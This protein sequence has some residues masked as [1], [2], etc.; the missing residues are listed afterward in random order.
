LTSSITDLIH[1]IPGSLVIFERN[2]TI[3]ACNRAAE[4]LFGYT[5]GN[6]QKQNINRILPSI[7]DAQIIKSQNNS[8]DSSLPRID[9]S[10]EIMGVHSGNGMFPTDVIVTPINI[11]SKG[12]FMASVTDLTMR[13]QA[14]NALKESE[15]QL[16]EQIAILHDT[17]DR[18]EMQSNELVT[19]AETLAQAKDQA[20]AAN[21]AKSE[22]LAMMSHEIRTPMNGV[23]GMTGLLLDTKLNEEQ[24]HYAETVRESGESLL[25]IINDILDFSKLE[26]GKLELEIINLDLHQVIDSVIELLAPK[27]RAK[28]V[29]LAAFIAPDVNTKLRGDPGRLR[30][31]LLN[32]LGNA[33]K[34]TETGAISVEVSSPPGR[35]APGHFL[36]EINDTGI[37]IPTDSQADLFSRF[38]QADSSVTRRYGGTG[39]GL[40]ICKELSRLMN[41]DIGV[42]S[43][44]GKGSTFWFTA[45]LKKTDEQ[46]QSS[47]KSGKFLKG[48]RIIII[49]DIETNRRIFQKVAESWGMI[50]ETAEDGPSALVKINAARD[51]GAPFDLAIVDQ[52]MPDMSGDELGQ[53]IR[54]DPANKNTFLLLASSMGMRGDE[55]FSRKIGFSA[56]LTK[57]IRQSVLYNCV[58][59]LFSP[60][61]GTEATNRLRD[62][63][64]NDQ[65][66]QASEASAEMRLR[67]LFAEDNHVNQLLVAALL[68]K[69]G[70]R[71]DVVGDG[72]EA[73]E[74]VRR[75]PYDLVLMDVQMPE[76]DG[77][78][79]TIA[80]RALP[81]CCRNI[82]IIAVTANAMK[83]DKESYLAAGMNDYL[84]KP[85]DHKKLKELV[86]KWGAKR[87]EPPKEAPKV[88]IEEDNSMM[89]KDVINMAI[90]D[91]LEITVGADNLAELLEQHISD[92]RER[93]EKMRFSA[94]KG[95]VNSLGQ[96]S[97]NL[98]STSGSF[99]AKRVQLLAQ[100]IETASKN[101]RQDKA[102]D[103]VPKLAEELDAALHI[104]EQQK[105]MLLEK[106][107]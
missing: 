16:R 57:P 4:D 44:P 77:V 50:T 70:H 29:E 101:Q 56:Y 94:R 26:A 105:K 67:I 58:A 98:K 38:T 106:A 13:L 68:K 82:P 28:G 78:E 107:P 103:L 91:E 64:D 52:M 17:K 11:G 33:I 85:V 60:N 55:E 49:D 59:N 89:P 39:L 72:H 102:F 69:E 53:I 84:S 66:S 1:T 42:E 41:G 71:V 79:A 5:K 6:L 18:Q 51:G 22:F 88:F 31:I 93:M 83:G 62:S 9:Q 54:K 20:E 99:G 74:A 27:A 8:V 15:D 75:L 19:M 36:F 76:M 100:E 34:F 45:E 14:A 81:G 95:D 10:W 32:L 80:I 23:I 46:E 73:V 48:R 104:L 86:L 97:H 7:S 92:A 37:G 63:E 61:N 43:E 35:I 65:A 30:Q 21:R 47:V 96:E 25:A 2:G 3:I 12:T 90:L 24:R 87:E 40:A